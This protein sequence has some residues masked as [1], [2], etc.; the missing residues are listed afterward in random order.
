MRTDD[1]LVNW[2]ELIVSDVVFD[3]SKDMWKYVWWPESRFL[4][5]KIGFSCEVG[6]E[7]V[8]CSFEDIKWTERGSILAETRGGEEKQT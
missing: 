7:R 1:R 4:L 3:G 5:V 8:E 6:E 2:T